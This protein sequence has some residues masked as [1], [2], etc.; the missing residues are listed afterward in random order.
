LKGLSRWRVVGGFLS[1]LPFLVMVSYSQEQ[2]NAWARLTSTPPALFAGVLIA[3]GCCLMWLIRARRIVGTVAVFLMGLTCCEK[4]TGGLCRGHCSKSLN[5]SVVAR[6]LNQW[7]GIAGA[8]LNR[9]VYHR[10]SRMQGAR[11]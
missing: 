6:V 7:H 3:S 11:L 9:G 2:A 4:L 5:I 1:C 8:L 10:K